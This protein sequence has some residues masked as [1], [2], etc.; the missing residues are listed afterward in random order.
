MPWQETSLEQQKEL[1]EHK[2]AYLNHYN[3]WIDLAR[4]EQLTPEGNW[5]TWLILAG[6]G[7]GK[8][9]TG[10]QDICNYALRNP[11]SQIAVITPTF[12]DLRRV[13]FG[14]I[15]GLLSMIPYECMLKGR[16]Q[17]YNSASAEIRL[18]NGSKIMGFSSTEPDRLRGVQ[19]HRAWCDELAS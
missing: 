1:D 15:S 4:A 19:F 3:K 14:G 8:T 6:R 18:A 17:G 11:N 5:S 2:I 16:G 7:W 9:T 13:A 12:G 10:A